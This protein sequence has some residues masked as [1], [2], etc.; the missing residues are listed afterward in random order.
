MTMK[1]DFRSE[2][3]LHRTNRGLF[4]REVLDDKERRAGLYQCLIAIKNKATSEDLVQTDTHRLLRN[5]QSYGKL[6]RCYT[7]NIDGLEARAGLNADMESND[8]N[9]VQLHGN[10][11]ALRCSY[12][13]HLTSW[14]GA[15]ER[16]LASGE[17]VPCP[18]CASRVEE[19]RRR[20]GRTNI[21]TGYLRPNIVLFQDI[22]DPLGETKAKIIDKDASLRPDVLLV[23]GTSLAIEGPRYELKSKL[24]PAVRRNNGRV[25]YVNNKPPPR[26]FAKPVIDHIFEMDC[27]FWA[28]DL[29][30]RES[31]S[32]EDEA[33]K[34]CRRIS[35]GFD[36]QPKAQTVDE[37]VREAELRLISIGDYSDVPFRTRT[38]EEVREDLSPFLPSRWLSTSPLMCALSLFRWDDCTTVLHSKHT[39]FDLNDVRKREE[40]LDGP[41]WPVGRKHS[42]V[43][44]P[45]NPS[46][47]WILVV[48]DLPIRN[49]S[50]YSS[51]SGYDLRGCCEFVEAQMKRVGE[52]FGRDYS[53]WNPPIE[54]V[55]TFPNSMSL[56]ANEC[57]AFMSTD[58]Q[59]GLWD[60]S[61]G[62]C[63]APQ[64]R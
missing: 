26:A 10:L 40:M 20:G 9:A 24:I 2:T 4:E 37:I 29:A 19:R 49:I 34:W 56:L 11:D 63:K 23:V 6:Q 28:R 59:L 45:Y 27:D 7:Q 31:S 8:C 1:Q 55:S 41:I 50:Y 22:D 52:R 30:T 38:K 15:H 58:Q 61:S 54:G 44:I 21:H 33:G 36:F 12:C 60:L 62:E 42:R 48:V 14:N 16:A 51:L 17:V 57:I 5:L 3:G 53:T 64:P 18:E 47:H 39:E 43:I 46:N 32:R 35:C 25:I 13:R